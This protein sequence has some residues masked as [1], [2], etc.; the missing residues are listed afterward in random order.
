MLALPLRLRLDSFARRRG[1]KYGPRDSFDF[2]FLISLNED[3]LDWFFHDTSCLTLNK[4]KWGVDTSVCRD[5]PERFGPG[6]QSISQ[7]SQLG[8][9][10]VTMKSIVP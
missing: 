3:R 2:H 4:S 5:A 6:A 8:A 9:L 1:T 10:L 7:A